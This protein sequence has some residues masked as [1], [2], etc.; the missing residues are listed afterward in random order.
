MPERDGYIP[1]VPCWIDTNQPDPNA[2]LPFYGGLFGWEF[3]DV[4]ARGIPRPLLHRPH[5]RWGRGRGGVG[6]RGRATGGRVEHLHL[7]RQRRR[8]GVE[9]RRRRWHGG[10]RALRRARRRADGGVRR[11]GGGGVLGV[12]AEG[13]QGREGRQRARRAELQRPRHAATR[14]RRRRSTARCS[15]GRRWPCRRGP[16]WALPGYGDH[17]EEAT[18][19][20][21]EQMAADGRA[22]G[23]HRRRR[24]ARADPDGDTETPAHWSVTFA[25]DDVD[26]TAAQVSELGGEVVAP[27][28]APW[29]R[30]AVINDPQGATFIAASS[31]RRTPTSK[32]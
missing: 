17:L 29:V 14:R 32:P 1:G 15:A 31:S 21:R 23:L 30:M 7:G 26:A 16:M 12:A 22:R 3:E 6:A 20:L 2:A 4:D 25:V 18:P 27:V 11:P 10:G 28:D 8:G 19:G 9:G 5:P 24:R 13:A